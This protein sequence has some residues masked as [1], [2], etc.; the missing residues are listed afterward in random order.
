MTAAQAAEAQTRLN[1]CLKDVVSFFEK[2]GI[3]DH[4]VTLLN[5]FIDNKKP[6]EFLNLADGYMKC[7]AF[8]DHDDLVVQ[9]LKCYQG[10]IDGYM[11]ERKITTKRIKNLKEDKKA[12]P[13]TVLKNE[14]LLIDIDNRKALAVA[15]CL[16][17]RVMSGIPLE[18]FKDKSF[19]GVAYK[20]KQID[21][22]K[23]LLSKPGTASAH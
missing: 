15:A 10:L 3:Q 5:G 19:D 7:M 23:G 21:H 2:N 16:K 4:S 11:I 8:I 9:I 22:K 20:K 6:L 17:F 1:L 14:N 18:L 12:D 13:E